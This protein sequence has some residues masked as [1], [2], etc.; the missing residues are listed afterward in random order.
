MTKEIQVL[1]FGDQSE[2]VIG[3]LQSL[4]LLKDNP[5]LSTFFEQAYLTLRTEVALFPHE[6]QNVA[7]FTSIETLLSRYSD[8]GVKNPAIES[9]LVNL[10]QTANL[11]R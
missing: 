11:L 4:V 10:Y 5:L 2:D 1:L 6:T 7:H 8:A 3:E 9:A